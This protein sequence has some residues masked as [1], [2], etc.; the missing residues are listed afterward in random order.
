[1]AH[2]FL[3][4]DTCNHT[5]KGP[6]LCLCNTDPRILLVQQSIWTASLPVP[7]DEC[8]LQLQQSW[9]TVHDDPQTTV[10][11]FLAHLFDLPEITTMLRQ[12]GWTGTNL[13]LVMHDDSRVPL[14]FLGDNWCAT[15]DKEGFTSTAAYA[16]QVLTVLQTVDD[17][18]RAIGELESI[19]PFLRGL[20]ARYAQ[21]GIQVEHIDIFEKAF[22]ATMKTTIGPSR[23]DEDMSAAWREAAQ[24]V[25]NI[26]V[27][28]LVQAHKEANIIKLVRTNRG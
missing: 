6:L 28:A 24:A 20:G 4:E 8:V 26:M 10:T 18:V 14:R 22:Y 9:V 12:A 15:G 21:Y 3:K 23:W 27:P 1:M 13:Q 19:I 17:I 16:K 5:C 25:K 11:G 2:E 7:D